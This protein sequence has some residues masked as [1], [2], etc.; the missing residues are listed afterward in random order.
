MDAHRNYRLFTFFI[1]LIIPNAFSKG[2][3]RGMSS[4][5]ASVSSRFPFTNSR[6]SQFSSQLFSSSV[7]SGAFYRSPSLGC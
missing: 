5:R 2:G 6:S 4:A 7:N 3:S 1:W